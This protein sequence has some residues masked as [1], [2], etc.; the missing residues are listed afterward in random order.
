MKRIKLLALIFSYQLVSA[1]T[2][3]QLLRVHNITNT[4]A[5]NTISSPLTGNL[6][7][8]QNHLYH[9]DGSQWRS[10]WTTRGNNN[11]GATGFLGTSNNAYFKLRTNNLRRMVVGYGKVGININNP[12][13]P[14]EV[15]ANISYDYSSNKSYSCTDNIPNE[16]GSNA[17]DD[18]DNNF[19][20]VGSI[21][22][23]YTFPIFVGV[24]L[25]NAEVVNYLR[26]VARAPNGPKDFRLTASN[27]NSDWT[28]VHSVTN[29]SWA[30]NINAKVYTFSN[31][32]A[33]RYFRL[34]VDAVQGNNN[35]LRVYEIDLKS[36]NPFVVT[37]NGNVG[38]ST[39]APTER[40]HVSGNILASGSITPD[41][42]F[43]NYYEGES[44]LNPIY[45]FR[46]LEK[47]QEFVKENK[48]LPGLPSAQDIENQ[49][50]III[51]R[52]TEMNLEKIEE[53][54]L[55]LFELHKEKNNIEKRLK[56]LEQKMEK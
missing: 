9:Y 43:E 54:Y 45:E 20:Y 5:L 31:S 7:Y 40:L 38:I 50:G 48:H 15:Q 52:S 24:D 10:P 26:L 17:F 12:S 27:N 16:D 41:Y 51:N 35:S 14:F 53:L 46:S 30:N 36:E 22:S 4:T 55:H 19:F 3:D 32:I 44:Q 42:V 8:T 6:A 28:D 2:A 25:G 18:L 33:Y 23:W 21:S 34:E 29:E 39:S 37:T 47:V 1:Q 13:H 56:R 49:G 11:I